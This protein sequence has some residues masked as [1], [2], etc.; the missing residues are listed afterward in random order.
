M[1]ARLPNTRRFSTSEIYTWGKVHCG[2]A[3]KKSLDFSFLLLYW[4]STRLVTLQACKPPCHPSDIFLQHTYKARWNFS[5]F[6]TRHLATPWPDTPS[7][8]LPIPPSWKATQDNISFKSVCSFL[9]IFKARFNRII[10]PIS[11]GSLKKKKKLPTRI[12]LTG[13]KNLSFCFP[14]ERHPSSPSSLGSARRGSP[15]SPRARGRGDSPLLLLRSA[16]QQLS[17]TLY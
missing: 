6:V 2:N 14:G 5:D 7:L 11:G 3:A 16:P 12:Y 15:P 1:W 9:Y 17:K 4:F 8:H 10:K 13:K